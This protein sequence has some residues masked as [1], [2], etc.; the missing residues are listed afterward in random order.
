M[1]GI[2]PESDDVQ[3]LGLSATRAAGVT[4]WRDD[5]LVVSSTDAS[6]APEAFEAWLRP[7]NYE[8]GEVIAQG[9]M[10]TILRTRDRNIRRPVA[11]KVLR[12]G[13]R[14]SPRGLAR[15]V[16]EAQVTGQPFRGLD[17]PGA[18][19]RQALSRND[20]VPGP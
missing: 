4:T 6:A 15:F 17:V 7:R 18:R 10:G 16:E 13:A 14:A 5:T 2:V 19:G 20:S 8:A 9:G 3:T 11:M 1:S 12:K